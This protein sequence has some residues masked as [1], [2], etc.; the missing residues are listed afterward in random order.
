MEAAGRSVD[1][2]VLA[3]TFVTPEALDAL[4]GLHDAQRRAFADE[5]P[6][7]STV[8]VEGFETPECQVQF[9]WLALQNPA[10]EVIPYRPGGVR[11]YRGDPLVFVPGVLPLD[12]AGEVVAA[13]DVVAQAIRVYERAWEA[14]KTAE[15]GWQS[16][17]KTV[18]YI[19]PAA[20]PAYRATAAVRRAA[21]G[22]R[23]PC[24]SGVV[25]PRLSHPDALIQVD[26]VATDRWQLT[27]NPG[28]EWYDHLTYVPA[29]RTGE[30]LFLSGIT[31][32][33]PHTGTPHLDDDFAGQMITVYGQLETLLR[34]AGADLSNLLTST[35]YVAPAAR[36]DWQRA[37]EVRQALFREP[38]PMVN[39]LL[40]T[41]LVR[42]GLLFESDGLA[43]L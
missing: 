13:G 22:K 25:V 4:D 41:S 8:V 15:L 39:G 14:L 38:Y 32:T 36:A 43:V 20:L 21:F 27:I 9:D 31:A 34:A 42:Q 18:E 23:F 33:D 7:V 24:A 37:A 5:E 40:C 17:V 30:L 10:V 12:A 26:F 6:A 2:V 16:V 11:A 1:E 35:E 3:T 28:W 19:T 29:I